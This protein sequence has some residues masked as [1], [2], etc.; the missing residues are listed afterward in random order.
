M[1]VGSTSNSSQTSSSN[2]S[3]SASS[4]NA[5]GQLDMDQ[6][7][8]LMISELQN[9]DPLNPMDNSQML[10]QISQIRSIGA[11]DKLTK[12][13][14][15]VLTGQNLSTAGSMIG[16]LVRGGST[17]GRL[18]EGK[19]DSVNVDRDSKTGATTLRVQVEGRAT[20]ATQT[21]ED[22][23]NAQI[24][25]TAVEPGE[26]MNG[27]AVAFVDNPAI[28]RGSESAQYNSATKTLSIQIHAGSST[29]GDVLKA[30]NS[31]DAVK[32]IFLARPAS[33]S[34]ASGLVRPADSTIL[35]SGGSQSIELDNVTEILPA[36]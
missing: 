33:G 3:S 13:L 8:K 11:T 7:L 19:V 22:N 31:N 1:S 18:I 15:A 32:N 12:T 16:K 2:S 24:Q 14:D 30:I 35:K 28:P 4:N 9:Q 34:D 17:D 10:Q 20:A 5:L 21:E 6:F 25:V 36:S 29:A 27:V 26:A 23:P